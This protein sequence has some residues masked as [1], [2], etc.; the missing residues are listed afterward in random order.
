MAPPL[1][2]VHLCVSG[3]VRALREINECSKAKMEVE[4]RGQGG[5]ALGQNRK[6]GGVENKTNNNKQD[7]RNKSNS[8]H[9]SNNHNNS[10]N[11]D[12]SNHHHHHHLRR[13][14]AGGHAT[15]ET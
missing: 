1:L 8:C 11:Q 7:N 10:D 4:G 5:R 6:C 13:W 2:Q 15:V 12:N 3:C 9:S 14:T